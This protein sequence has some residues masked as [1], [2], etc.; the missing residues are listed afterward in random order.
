MLAPVVVALTVCAPATGQVDAELAER[1][2]IAALAID[3]PIVVDGRLDEPAWHSAEVGAGFRQ[4][5]PREGAP[6]SERTEFSIAFTPSTLYVA[7]RAFD[8]EPGRI[9]AKEMERDAELT[10]DDSFVLVFDTFLDGRNAFAF[11]TNPNGARH[12]ALV[13]DE[14]RDVNTEWDGVWSVKARRTTDGWTAEIAIPFATLRFDPALDRWGLHVQRLIR[15]KNEEVNWAY[16]PRSALPITTSGVAHEAAY[17]VSLAGRLTGLAGLRSSRSLDVKPYLIGSASE[18]PRARTSATDLD[19]GLDIK[20][21]LSKSMALDLTYNTDFA[22]VEVDDLQVNLTRFSLFFPEK[23]DFFLENAGIFEFG[24]PQRVPWL[25]ALMKAF[26]SRRIGLDGG[27]T[28]PM[29]LGARLTGR[30]GEWNLG[31]LGVGT[32]EADV[33]SRSVPQTAFSVARVKRNIGQR[34]SVGAIFT[35]RDPAAAGAES[36]YGFDIELKPT[37]L[38][39]LNGYWSRSERP[40]IDGDDASFGAGVGYQ[41]STLTTSL[42]FIESQQNFDPGVG[43]LLRENFRLFN[44]RFIWQP[45]IERAGIRSWYAEGAHRRFERSSD[46]R[47]ESEDTYVYPLGMILKTNDFFEFGAVRTKERIFAPFEIFPGVVIPPGLFEFDGW[48][49]LSVTDA[50]RSVSLRSFNNWGEFYQGDWVS[51]RQT[52]GLRLSRLVRASTTWSH[53][54]VDLPQGAFEINLWSQG[55]DLSFTPNLR[56]NMIAQ[57]NDAA[58]D[59]GVNIRFHWIYRPGA[60]IFLVYNENW[61]APSLRE[62]RTE[63]RQLILKATYLF[64]R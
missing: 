61:T 39:Q 9:I 10:S 2:S 55:L 38:L 34:S 64:Q 30:L 3:D 52:V 24:P 28:V 60:D 54:D 50:S 16:L 17:R 37:Q 49:L 20:W 12:D 14:G 23:R 59:L 56:L 44:P 15:R 58:E 8:R 6:A 21:G 22:E 19:G 31:V 29:D 40:G 33:G 42:D 7:L 47:L 25:P 4:R 45:R 35:Q 57:Y 41:G 53:H 36:L 13:T 46:G 51:L 63:G 18:E 62:R 32:G 26:F 27:E 11:A 48:E 5:E 1:P 43:F